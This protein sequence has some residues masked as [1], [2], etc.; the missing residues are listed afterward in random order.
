MR[1][2][3]IS[4]VNLTLT[5]TMAR[6]LILTLAKLC[7]AFAN[8]LVHFANCADTQIAHNT[9][10]FLF[11]CQCCCRLMFE[12]YRYRV[13]VDTKTIEQYQY[14]AIFTLYSHAILVSCNCW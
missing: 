4:D 1:N 10:I 2:L 12:R 6:T 13:S 7:S 9:C 3:Q 8:R 11:D 5:M 14:S